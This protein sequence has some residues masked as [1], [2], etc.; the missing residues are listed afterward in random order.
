MLRRQPRAG[1]ADK[2]RDRRAGAEGR[3]RAQQSRHAVCAQAP[4]TAQNPF[5]PLR[6]EEALDIGNNK[7]ENAQ[8]NHDLDG[9]IE[10]KP[11]AAAHSADSVQPQG[12]KSPADQFV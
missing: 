4:E 5:R 12:R 7:N 11:Y 1:K 6:R 3:H 10:K 8:Q 2:Q 9:V